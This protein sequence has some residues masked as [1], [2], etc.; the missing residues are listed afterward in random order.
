MNSS[1][2][3]TEQ[4]DDGYWWIVGLSPDDHSLGPF[5]NREDISGFVAKYTD[6]LEGHC[7]VP[8]GVKVRGFD[9]CV[10]YE[11]NFKM[12]PH[13]NDEYIEELVSE[14]IAVH[15]AGTEYI[16]VLKQKIKDSSG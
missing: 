3:T 4:S 15:S 11:W 7:Q 13:E 2:L 9:L 14:V 10:A 16:A 8:T 12:T 1:N 6:W 5:A